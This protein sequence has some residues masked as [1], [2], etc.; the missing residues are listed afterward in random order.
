MVRG[1]QTYAF[2]NLELSHKMMD[3]YRQIYN[4]LDFAGDFGG[5]YGLVILVGS[6]IVAAMAQ[7]SFTLK[8]IR[9]LYLVQ[10]KKDGMFL[11]PRSE[12]YMKKHAERATV[13]R[14]M[15]RESKQKIKNNRVAKV[16]LSRSVKLFF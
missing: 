3:H 10:T 14:N 8:A 11:A 6:I 15:D 4:A 7:H 12:K 2:M 5:V 13:M 9:K 1:R 16:D